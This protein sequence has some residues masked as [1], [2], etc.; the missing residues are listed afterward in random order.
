M[1]IWADL[2]GGCPTCVAEGAEAGP[3]V[4]WYHATCGGRMEVS[5]EARLKCG[6]CGTEGHIQNWK[7]ACPRQGEPS[8]KV[9]YCPTSVSSTAVSIAVG[10]AICPK[11]GKAWLMRFLDNLGAW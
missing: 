9:Y 6:S 8:Y 5:D 7:W 3:A 1:A 4:Q 11:M 10:A 2:V